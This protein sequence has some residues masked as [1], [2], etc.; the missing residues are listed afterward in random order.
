LEFSQI[1]DLLKTLHTSDS[2]ILSKIGLGKLEKS[3]Q[4]FPVR[5]EEKSLLIL[6]SVEIKKEKI[7]DLSGEELASNIIVL[8]KFLG[9]PNQWMKVWPKQRA[10]DIV[11]ASSDDDEDFEMEIHS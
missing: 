11:E 6:V 4:A 9:N 2:Q 10:A 7:Q 3:F 5:Y 1:K 8:A